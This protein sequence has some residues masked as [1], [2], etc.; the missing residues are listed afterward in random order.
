MFYVG[1][2][3]VHFREPNQNA[4][5]GALKLFPLV[6]EVLGRKKDHAGTAWSRV[7]QRSYQTEPCLW[8]ISEALALHLE[9]GVLS[10]LCDTLPLQTLWSL[11][12]TSENLRA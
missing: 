6:G 3:Q 1:Q 11:A 7:A 8:G 4:L 5:P 10:W 2:L 9:P 12:S